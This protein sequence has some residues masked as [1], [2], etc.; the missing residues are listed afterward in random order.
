[1]RRA[2][3]SGQQPFPNLFEKKP[4]PVSFHRLQTHL[5]HTRRAA[6]A[7]HPLVRLFQYILAAYLIVESREPPLR[8]LLGCAVE[9]PLQFA[10]IRQPLLRF[11]P[12]VDTPGSSLPSRGHSGHLSSF[13]THGESSGPFLRSVLPTFAGT[14]T[15]S[16]FP[17]GIGSDGKIG[18]RAQIGGRLTY[19]LCSAIGFLIT[20]MPITTSTLSLTSPTGARIN[21]MVLRF[22]KVIV[23]RTH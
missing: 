19:F 15:T 6:I 13:W 17:T 16:D 21:P 8:L 12:S 20:G 7:L 18:G 23:D 2:V 22:Q 14:M 5:V 9:R 10:G 4:F 1:M 11:A 3:T